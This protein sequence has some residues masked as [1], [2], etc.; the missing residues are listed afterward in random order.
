M[1]PHRPWVNV[2]LME[3]D[4]RI[5]KD[6]Q[7]EKEEWRLRQTQLVK[8][9]IKVKEPEKQ[10][11]TQ[12]KIEEK[13]GEK[14]EQ[15]EKERAERKKQ[16][17]IEKEKQKA[18]QDKRLQK[19][20]E[21]K[22]RAAEEQKAE[23][24]KRR[25]EKRIQKKTGKLKKRQETNQSKELLEK[26]AKR[27][28]KI[29]ERKEKAE[30]KALYQKVAAKRKKEKK[31]PAEEKRLKQIDKEKQRS[32]QDERQR[33]LHA[34]EEEVRQS[35]GL[36][37]TVPEQERL[38]REQKR[39]EKEF[40]NWKVA[41]KK[42]QEKLTD[43]K[44]AQEREKTL[45]DEQRKTEIK[46]EKVK[47]EPESKGDQSGISVAQMAKKVEARKTQLAQQERAL[48]KPITIYFHDATLSEM[49]E[50]LQ[51]M[52]GADFVIPDEVKQ[53]Q[54]RRTLFIQEM[55]LGDALQQ[56]LKDKEFVYSIKNQTVSI[57]KPVTSH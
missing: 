54:D 16:K 44:K 13:I 38:A 49:F 20:R 51:K 31:K 52:T 26:E 1:D 12:E 22:R 29:A 3:I 2:F 39:L 17:Q 33:E 46:K 25:E 4:A 7:R 6:T 53:D 9:E 10:K 55:P 34:K 37:E 21:E 32:E 18:E 11:A 30:A 5:Q 56:I 57:T 47:L 27:Y 14:K 42:S 24:E 50:H 35:Q 19:V 41:K 45:E 8:P 23:K 43:G 15:A 28:K 48:S 40:L 36:N